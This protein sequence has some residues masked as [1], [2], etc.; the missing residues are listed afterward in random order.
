MVTGR[1]IDIHSMKDVSLFI[2]LALLFVFN[3]IGGQTIFWQ[4]GMANYSLTGL[5]AFGFLS[6][7]RPLLDKKNYISGSLLSKIAVFVLGF[8]AGMSNEN[9]S[10]IFLCIIFGILIYYKVNRIT[11]PAWFY[12]A[13]CG[14]ILGV[15]ALLG[16]PGSYRRIS[17]ITDFYVSDIFNRLHLHETSQQYLESSLLEKL[18]FLPM[19]VGKFV[20]LA[21]GLPVIT[22]AANICILLK[23]KLKFQ[24]NRYVYYSL[25]FLFIGFAL[26]GILCFAPKPSIRAYYA[27]IMFSNMSFAFLLLYLTNEFKAKILSTIL[28]S[29]FCITGIIGACILLPAFHKLHTI[30][31]INLELIST[32]R[33]T[34]EK[35]AELYTPRQSFSYMYS[36]MGDIT[37]DETFWINVAMAKYYGLNSVVK[38]MEYPE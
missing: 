6:L 2:I 18:Q 3:T 11:L 14:N 31:N 9:M 20:V 5:I 29:T 10:V 22:L 35:R 30:N 28:V 25:G 36:N 38:K 17:F 32:A 4:A 37:E 19:R 33:E 12:W 21:L 8:L 1:K 13:L 27:P 15:M 34:P 26:S 16:A 7:F 24:H 23:K